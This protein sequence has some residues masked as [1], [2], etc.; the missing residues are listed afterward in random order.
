MKPNRNACMQGL[1]NMLADESLFL[2]AVDVA[3]NFLL[4][5]HI[6]DYAG[7]S[8]L[9]A[10]CPVTGRNQELGRSCWGD[11]H[12]RGLHSQITPRSSLSAAYPFLSFASSNMTTQPELSDCTVNRRFHSDRISGAEPK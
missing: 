7:E 12:W 5:A 9:G 1:R 10:T 11:A 2:P 6:A 3:I 4:V 8:V